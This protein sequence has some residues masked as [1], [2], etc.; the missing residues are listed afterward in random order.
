YIVYTIILFCVISI[1]LSLCLIFFFI[2]WRSFIF[3]FFPYTTL[4]RSSAFILKYC[5]IIGVVFDIF[6]PPESYLSCNYNIYSY[7]LTIFPYTNY[8]I[9]VILYLISLVTE[10]YFCNYII[11]YWMCV[12]FL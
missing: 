1:S 12:Y 4:F 3:T 9:T 11:L 2:I 5:F 10:E 6:V 8:L 7:K